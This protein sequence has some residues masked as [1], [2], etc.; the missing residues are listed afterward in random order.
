MIVYIFVL[1]TSVKITSMNWAN[2]ILKVEGEIRS[3]RLRV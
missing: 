1:F 2:N 3:G